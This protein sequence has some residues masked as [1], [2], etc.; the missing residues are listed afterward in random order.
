MSHFEKENDDA[1]L[2]KEESKCS[3]AKSVYVVHWHKVIWLPMWIRVHYASLCGAM[4]HGHL[5]VH[6]TQ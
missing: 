3:K 5:I 2:A 6:V 4:A 1:Q